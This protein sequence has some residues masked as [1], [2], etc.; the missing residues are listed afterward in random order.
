MA[1][2]ENFYSSAFLVDDV[3]HKNWAMGKFAHTSSFTEHSSETRELYQEFN[4]VQES[5]AKARCGFGII[6]GYIA[7]NFR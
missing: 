1:E 7:K 6:F 5:G 2:M 4:M 3:I